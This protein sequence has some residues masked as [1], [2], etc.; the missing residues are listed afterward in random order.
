MA[1]HAARRQS[2]RI[3]SALLCLL[4]LVL[5]AVTVAQGGGPLSRGVIIG[6]LFALLGAGRVLLARDVRG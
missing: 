4:G 3:L 1:V 2:T 5:I 6:A